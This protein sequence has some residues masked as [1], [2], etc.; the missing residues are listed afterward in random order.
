MGRWTTGVKIFAFRK[1]LRNYLYP[2]RQFTH[3]RPVEGLDKVAARFSCQE[4]AWEWLMAPN[5]M[6]GGKPP[7]DI[8]HE[9]KINEVVDAAEGALDFA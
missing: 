7:I 2:L 6:T 9:G 1:G 3:L 5:R 8:L 4:E